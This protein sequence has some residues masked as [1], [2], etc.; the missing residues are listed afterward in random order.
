MF[1]KYFVFTD[2]EDNVKLIVEKDKLNQH[3]PEIIENFHNWSWETVPEGEI[4]KLK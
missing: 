1:Y 3:I 2:K 4:D